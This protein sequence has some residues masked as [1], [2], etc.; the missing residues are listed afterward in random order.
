MTADG[1]ST[2]L[3]MGVSDALTRAKRDDAAVV[4]ITDGIDNVSANAADAIR[5]SAHPVHT[6][7]V[8]SD[9][10]TPA[11]VVNVA[12]DDVAAPDDFAVNHE[13]NVTATIR[14]TGLAGRVVEVKL[15]ETD[16][17]GKPTGE[18]KSQRL[19]LQPTPDG[20]RV[21]LP[22]R[23]T[24]A[25][26][27]T[28]SVWV[29]PVA[30][31]RTTADNRQTFQGLAVDPRI[32]VLYVE[33][34]VRLE[35]KWTRLAFLSDANV[36]LATY[37]RKTATSV[38]AGGTVDGKPFHALP[39]TAAG[40]AQFDVVVIGDIDASYLGPQVARIE[41]RTAGAAGC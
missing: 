11:S 1:T 31:E 18:V 41:Q 7:R 35:Y 29:D 39:T 23:P 12:V 25:G 14:S 26:L 33:G 17:A 28:A 10:A 38:E 4:L 16:A 24:T 32:K 20:Q 21:T 9:Q 2:D 37:L 36:E 13:S 19:V 8:G 22:F 6:V 5:G 27:H 15:A 30:G 34:S 40:W 3:V